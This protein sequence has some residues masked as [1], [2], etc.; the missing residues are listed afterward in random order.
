MFLYIY[1]LSLPPSL[2]HLSLLPSPLSVV[3]VVVVCV[4]I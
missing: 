1:Y 3:V 4:E 2:P